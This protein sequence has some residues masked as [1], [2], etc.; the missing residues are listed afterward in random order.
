MN[1]ETIKYTWIQGWKNS[2]A[3][4]NEN[5]TVEM[6]IVMT[7][8]EPTDEEKQRVIMMCEIFIAKTNVAKPE[9]M[10]PLLGEAASTERTEAEGM[11][12]AHG[13]WRNEYEL[14]PVI[15]I[16]AEFGALAHRLKNEAV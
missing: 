11:L 8:D 6:N 3:I 16:I 9:A 13:Y 2:F 15:A 10:L 12:K 7:A 14:N 4:I 1:R 5:G